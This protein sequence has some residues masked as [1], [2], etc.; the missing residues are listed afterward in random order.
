MA[1]LRIAFMV[2]G[3]VF[4]ARELLKH[5]NMRNTFFCTAG[6]LLIFKKIVIGSNLDSI[7]P[8]F[9]INIIIIL[10]ATTLLMLLMIKASTLH[11]SIRKAMPEETHD[12]NEYKAK[13]NTEGRKHILSLIDDIEW[14]SADNKSRYSSIKESINILNNTLELDLLEHTRN[15][16]NK[17]AGFLT[18][19]QK[20]CI[21]SFT[22][23]INGK[24]AQGAYHELYDFIESCGMLDGKPID[25]IEKIIIKNE[26][27][28]IENLMEKQC[29]I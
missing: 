29:T 23:N 28:Q 16:E 3:I 4:L 14:S 2:L 24:N 25:I 7:V 13:N 18:E 10:A 5:Q 6:I 22:Y 20:Q 1:Y 21:F 26:I 17:L 15:N 27:M 8:T 11:V 12:I 9:I 19:R